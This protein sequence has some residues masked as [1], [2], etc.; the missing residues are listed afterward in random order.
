MCYTVDTPSIKIE[1][2]TGREDSNGNPQ[3][4]SLT[5]KQAV[6]MWDEILKSLR[7]Q[8]QQAR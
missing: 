6:K 1:M 2:T 3:Q 5:D 7:V 4:T 8:P